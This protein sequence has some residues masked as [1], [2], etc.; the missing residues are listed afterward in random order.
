MQDHGAV[1]FFCRQKNI[2]TI[3][4]LVSLEVLVRMIDTCRCAESVALGARC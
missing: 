3:N 4:E 2:T 1:F